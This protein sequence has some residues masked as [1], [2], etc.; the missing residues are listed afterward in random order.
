MNGIRVKCRFSCRQSRSILRTSGMHILIRPAEEIRLCVLPL[1][2]CFE[3]R[4]FGSAP[5]FSRYTRPHH[6]PVPSPNNSARTSAPTSFVEEIGEGGMGTVF[7][8]TQKE[9]VRRKVA[10]KVIKP[11][12]DTKRGRHPLRGRAASLGDDGSSQHRQGARRWH[13]RI[14]AALLCDGAGQRHADHRLLRP[15]RLTTRRATGI[16]CATSAALSSMPIRKAS[17]TAT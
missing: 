4:D 9:P 3:P 6:R 15:H 10:L 17:S 5:R 13:H 16:V 11:G 12:M 2:H 7:M 14:G 1:R 8:A